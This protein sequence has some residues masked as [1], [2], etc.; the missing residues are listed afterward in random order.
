M[1][2]PRPP[3]PPHLCKAARFVHQLHKVAPATRPQLLLGGHR[4]RRLQPCRRTE[5]RAHRDAAGVDAVVVAIV[6][7][8]AVVGG[9]GAGQCREL[10][11]VGGGP[12][13][14]GGQ[15]VAVKGGLRSWVTGG[16][17]MVLLLL[18]SGA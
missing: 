17:A 14:A 16:M 10:L 7:L 18:W 13:L 9:G 15:W 6:A 4:S 3:P 8:L 12:R 1:D 11:C 2:A 5:E